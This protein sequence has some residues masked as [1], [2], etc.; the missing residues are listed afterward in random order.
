MKKK[1]Q[2][3]VKDLKDNPLISENEIKDLEEMDKKFGTLLKP[4]D[5][6]YSDDSKPIR[7]QFDEYFR[8]KLKSDT[9]EN[10]VKNTPHD[11][12][13]LVQTA[14]GGVALCGR[15]Y[16]EN[17][18]KYN[19]VHR[20]VIQPPTDVVLKQP[21]LPSEERT[22]ELESRKQAD[23]FNVSLQKMGGVLSLIQSVT[24]VNGEITSQKQSTKNSR[25][26]FFSRIHCQ[27]IPTGAIQ[28]NP[29][30]LKLSE[31]AL[32]ALKNIEL[33]IKIKGYDED[34][35]SACRDFV[36]K[37]GT[38]VYVGIVH[39]GG[40]YTLEA[41]YDSN[42]TQSMEEIKSLVAIKSNLACLHGIAASLALK[43]TGVTTS[44]MH[45]L[46]TSSTVR[47]RSDIRGGPK[48]VG[49]VEKW[50]NGL[51]SDRCTWA[52][53]SCESSNQTDYIPVSDLIQNC[54]EM[55]NAL[56]KA[57]EPMVISELIDPDFNYIYEAKSKL[58]KLTTN[59]ETTYSHD[60]MVLVEIMWLCNVDFCTNENWIKLFQE[61]RS[62]S[63]FLIQ[64]P[65]QDLDES[66]ESLVRLRL[67]RLIEHLSIRVF[68]EKGD[69]LKWLQINKVA[70]EKQ[71]KE[72]LAAISVCNAI[73]R[74]IN[75]AFKATFGDEIENELRKS[76]PKSKQE[77]I[78]EVLLGLT[79]SKNFV[80]YRKFI[81]DP[82]GWTKEYIHKQLF[83]H[84]I[85]STAHC[86]KLVRKYVY[87]CV[88]NTENSI[89]A[90][91]KYCTG[92]AENGIT[93]WMQIFVEC[94][95]PDLK[96][97]AASV[98]SIQHF[99]NVN[100]P[101]F[102]KILIENMLELVDDIMKETEATV[103]EVA[104]QKIWGCTSSCPFC[105]E[106]CRVVAENLSHKT[107]SCYKHRPLCVTGTTM[108]NNK[109]NKKELIVKTCD[110][111]TKSDNKFNCSSCGF[112]CRKS[113]NCSVQEALGT[114]VDVQEPLK[115]DTPVNDP[116]VACEMRSEYWHEFKKYET[117]LPNWDL[118]GTV[119][120]RISDY[121]KWFVCNYRE[122]LQ[123]EFG[124]HLTDI[125]A[126][127]KSVTKQKAIASLSE[128]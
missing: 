77:L 124:A 33:K 53:I 125:P 82:T 10:T 78:A 40:E 107:H 81:T 3:A 60:L 35:R 56:R 5:W 16:D 34:V 73:K 43:A 121:W 84:K 92:Q 55:A 126:R 41:T 32:K 14:S 85:A 18:K 111:M 15:S 12:C 108:Y 44:A 47:L 31:E 54:P 45:N 71:S 36:A 58:L 1:A 6:K 120:I 59:Q 17:E 76:L 64:G 27:W 106:P 37:F 38:H 70:V 87:K 21:I 113:G 69:I 9:D 65:K 97:P 86:L 67:E 105:G 13:A 102:H 80:S 20:Q 11:L 88:I 116:T 83:E 74:A 7:E 104:V 19:K 100:I 22:F 29:N 52:V 123:E 4:K 75:A 61:D 91:T 127:W 39:L 57:L 50:K 24:D 90:A 42:T 79:E 122:E 99:G 96:I 30:T 8:E 94:A 95:K 112:M 2:D 128:Q 25:E 49:S 109:T 63:K 115:T 62:I 23:V 72:Q 98:K 114:N 48:H 28:F 93:H 89:L 46:D 68:P 51:V 26:K 103:L 110:E 118:D 66:E 101:K 119:S 117:Y